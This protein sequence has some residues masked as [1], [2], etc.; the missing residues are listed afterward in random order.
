MKCVGGQSHEG[1]PLSLNHKLDEKTAAHKPHQ[2]KS[3]AIESDMPS[4]RIA[5]VSFDIAHSRSYWKV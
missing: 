4:G 5:D 2:Y 1:D 3:G